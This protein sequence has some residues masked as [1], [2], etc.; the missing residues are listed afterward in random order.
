MAPTS[1]VA[2][3]EFSPLK[4]T[5]QSWD[6]DLPADHHLIHLTKR[7][8]SPQEAF[9][10]NVITHSVEVR[11]QPPLSVTAISGSGSLY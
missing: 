3:H 10:L 11:V 2:L 9:D 7:T 6:C 5:K 8:S 1:R 4:A